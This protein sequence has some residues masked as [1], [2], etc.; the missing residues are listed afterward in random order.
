M[1]VCCL[2]AAAVRIGAETSLQPGHAQSLP[3]LLASQPLA[4][5]PLLHAIARRAPSVATLARNPRGH[6]SQRWRYRHRCKVG[7]RGSC[8]R[9]PRR[10]IRRSGSTPTLTVAAV[11]DSLA[12]S[13]YALAPR[14]IEQQERRLD[15]LR[16]RAGT[17]IAAASV[18]ASL[19]ASRA[20]AGKPD[21][22]GVAAL[23]AHLVCV[24]CAL[25]VLVPIASCWS[26]AARRSRGWTQLSARGGSEQFVAVGRRASESPRTACKHAEHGEEPSL[27]QAV[28]VC[29][30]RP[31]DGRR[32]GFL[33]GEGEDALIFAVADG[34]YLGELGDS[35]RLA[36][37]SSP[38]ALA[39]SEPNAW[40]A[41]RRT[42]L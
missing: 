36:A 39:R 12:E 15:E 31:G 21:A 18:A 16:S 42:G 34:H 41:R 8:C 7:R 6:F 22:I 14:A 13:A 3:A 33:D 26:S 19:L 10:A 23:V 40:H 37:G 25:L 17:L 5:D 1:A 24:G 32:V 28:I 30:G 11:A 20:A 2:R 35:D 9:S 4:A 38:R 27:R 29:R